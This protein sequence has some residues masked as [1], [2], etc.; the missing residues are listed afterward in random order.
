M[1]P[2][3]DIFSGR[4]DDVGSVLGADGNVPPSVVVQGF[5]TLTPTAEVT[6]YVNLWERL[7]TTSTS[8]PTR[9]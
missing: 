7:G 5:R 2:L 9:R 8:R 1:G 4:R 3:A 6:R